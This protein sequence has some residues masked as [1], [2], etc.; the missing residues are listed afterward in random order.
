ME[1]AR[2]IVSNSMNPRIQILLIT[3]LLL[4]GVSF[5]PG[6]AA[7]NSGIR[8]YEENPRFW[9][10]QGGPVWL[11]GGSDDDNLF[12]M[13]HLVTHLDEIKAVG[14]NYIRNT[15]S[16]RNDRGW[17]VY[18]FKQL[19]SGKY[20]L[21][22]WNEEYW[23]RF[24]LMLEQT[25]ARGIFV[26]IEIWD[27]FDYSREHWQPNPYNPANNVNYTYEES[28]FAPEYPDHPGRNV[29][30]FFFTTPEQRNNELILR[31]QRRFVDRMLSHSLKYDHVLYC[32]DNETSGEEAWA[33]YWAERVRQRAT[34]AGVSVPITQMWDDWDLTAERHM[35]TLGHPERY[36][37]A[38]VSQNNQKKGQVHWDNFQWV[39]EFVAE[40][41]R[42]LNTVKTYGA[43]GGRHGNTRDG[44]ERWW[45]HVMGGAASARF[46]RPDSGLGLSDLAK[47]SIRTARIMEEHLKPWNAAP[48]NELL[49][50]REENEAFA[51]AVPGTA[52][53]VYFTDG[54]EVALDL[55][56]ASG[57][58]ALSWFRI[59][60]GEVAQEAEIEGGGTV[61]LNPPADGHWL[62]LLTRRP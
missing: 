42:P 28:G 54:G 51:C 52:Y 22:Q 53:A 11:L 59:E 41:P 23:R 57:E 61:R 1:R 10:Y 60:T 49:S 35:R 12:Q 40:Q 16:D 29:Q 20:D 6:V 47:A 15:M 32:I 58:L 5:S 45:R 7:E 31:F 13:P 9:Q 34:E 38:D 55:A 50:D 46:H 36:D 4:C 56:T 8:P 25:R 26:Q 62:A 39:R 17:E 43:D 27:R 2:F 21:D 44:L 30:P 24:E 33:T 48:A 37:F 18:P 3:L 14:G 19:D